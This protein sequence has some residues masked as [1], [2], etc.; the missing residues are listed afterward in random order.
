MQ[1]EFKWKKKE[2]KMRKNSGKKMTQIKIVI[3]DLT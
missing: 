2:L 3:F 1:V